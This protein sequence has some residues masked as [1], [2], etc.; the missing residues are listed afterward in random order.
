METFT[1]TSE[2]GE[3]YKDCYFVQSKYPNGNLKLDIWGIIPEDGNW[4]QPISTVTVN[5]GK[6]PKTQIAIKSYGENE[7]MLEFLQTLGLV[8]QPVMLE[9]SG[10]VT[11]PVCEINLE[12]LHKYN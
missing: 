6:Q 9:R 1:Y 4:N 12:V 11:I 10:Y 7:G 8:G 3:T 5:V 2:F